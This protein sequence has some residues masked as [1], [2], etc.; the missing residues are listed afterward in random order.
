MQNYQY[1]VIA[2]SDSDML[3]DKVRP[4]T[5]ADLDRYSS[6][7]ILEYFIW[8]IYMTRPP[9]HLIILLW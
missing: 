2:N 1:E 6:F 7:S 4:L 8:C 9:P 5:E 3:S